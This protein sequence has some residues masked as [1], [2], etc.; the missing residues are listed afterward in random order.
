M[1]LHAEVHEINLTMQEAM[2]AEGFHS[3]AMGLLASTDSLLLSL[4]CY[5]RQAVLYPPDEPMDG[6]F[7]EEGKTMFRVRRVD[8]D[9][10][11]YYEVE[12]R[13]PVRSSA[14]PGADSR[15][16]YGAA[17]RFTPAPGAEI[18][19]TNPLSVAFWR[20]GRS[21][22]LSTPNPERLTPAG[23]VRGL[24]R[25]TSRLKDLHMYMDVQR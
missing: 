1:K 20:A 12:S 11:F 8:G 16:V 17:Y 4:D 25:A 14:R 19:L 10:D 24:A 2:G 9:R 22:Y 18:T 7:P 6:A 3:A 23:V 5:P 21:E 13:L 15:D